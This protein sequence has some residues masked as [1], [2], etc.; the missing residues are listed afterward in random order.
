MFFLHNLHKTCR[1]TFQFHGV[2]SIECT[3]SILGYNLEVIFSDKP[4][5]IPL[6][7]TILGTEILF[8]FQL[9]LGSRNLSK[10]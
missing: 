6:F 1:G 3:W 9:L 8:C 4:K 2:C 7:S 10:S 5:T